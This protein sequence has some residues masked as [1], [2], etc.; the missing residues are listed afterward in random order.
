MTFE[1]AH[2]TAAALLQ[3]R[4]QMLN[5]H[6]LRLVDGDKDLFRNVRESLIREGLAEDR[7]GIGLAV[8]PVG[9]AL[10]TVSLKNE[11]IQTETESHPTEQLPTERDWWV[12]VSG[13]TQGPFDLDTLLR[14]QRLGEIAPGDVIRRGTRGLWQQQSELQRLVRRQDSA[15]TLTFHPAVADLVASADRVLQLNGQ[16]AGREALR[17]IRTDPQFPGASV[18]VTTEPPRHYVPPGKIWSQGDLRRPSW[19]RQIWDS[20]A[21]LC[22][23]SKRLVQIL[24]I[25]AAISVLT[26]WW[27]QPPPVNTIYRE[28]TDYNSLLQKLRERRIGRSEWAP[29]VSRL[30]PRVSSIVSRLQFRRSPA[31]K[32]LY[33]AG[34]QGLLPLL[35][36]P[37][38]P[39]NAERAFDKHMAAARQLIDVKLVPSQPASPGK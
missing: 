18:A 21:V 38:D 17:G 39:T 35:E 8:N 16:A 2:R 7:A 22:G 30:R 34:T 28:F 1:E 10:E 31:E 29:T 12:M 26:Y 37:A 11:A 5:G 9:A 33:L 24:L 32:E 20:I 36:I 13:Q 23:G 19:L 14:M 15:A 25:L 6:L 4:G 27:R 3:Q